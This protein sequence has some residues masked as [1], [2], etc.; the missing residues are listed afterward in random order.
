MIGYHDPSTKS[1]FFFF[2]ATPNL[3]DV[4]RRDRS[5]MSN[6]AKDEKK[7]KKPKKFERVMGIN[8]FYLP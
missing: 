1:A 7:K 6:K 8:F 4:Y 2:V 3:N 5:I